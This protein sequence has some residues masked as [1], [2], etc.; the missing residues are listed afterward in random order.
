MIHGAGC[1]SELSFCIIFAASVAEFVAF[2][3]SLLK[4]FISLK[5]LEG[6][7]NKRMRNPICGH[8]KRDTLT[9]N[10]S[11]S[12]GD[13]SAITILGFHAGSPS[14]RDSSTFSLRCF[15]KQISL[16]EIQHLHTM[17]SG[18]PCR[19]GETDDHV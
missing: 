8:V 7:R 2:Q 16:A 6:I 13:P 4:T 11:K 15:F 5:L 18:T 14:A 19:E 17:A 10:G 12:S 9:A 3:F 1:A